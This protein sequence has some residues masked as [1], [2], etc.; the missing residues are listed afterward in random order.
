MQPIGLAASFL[1]FGIPSAI[2][3]W[4]MLWWLPR[5]MASGMSLL[6][7]F[8]LTFATPLALMLLAALVVYRREGNAW[9]WPAFRERMRLR[10]MN[11][12]DWLW[13]IGAVAGVMLVGRL[14]S[15]LLG[16]HELIRFYTHPA[17]FTEFMTRMS[18][19]G[20]EWVGIPLKG[21]W[22]VLVA[23]IVVLLVFNI[24]G[25]E[26]WWRGIILPRQ[27]LALGQYAWI[28][29]GVLWAAFHAFYHTTLASFLMFVPG[30]TL[31]A[32]VCQKRKST[33]PG[34]IAHTI[35]NS[36]MPIM[37]AKGIMS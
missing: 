6:P 33:W 5:L 7:I 29:N 3:S 24:F 20:P 36:A 23:Y 13:T 25:E 26:L 19:I 8:L 18:T 27:E 14:L 12:G 37:L 17:G 28:V 30:T 16:G 1:W 10:R 22:L 2:F 21:N 32:F 34:I 4:F 9:T 15:P 31:I 11:A 35:Q